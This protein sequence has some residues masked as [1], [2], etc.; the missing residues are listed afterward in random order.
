M[1]DMPFPIQEIYPAAISQQDSPLIVNSGGLALRLGDPVHDETVVY[2]PRANR[3]TEGVSLPAPRHHIAL[4]WDG[5][6][7]HA[8]GGFT[9]RGL[10]LWEMRSEHWVIDDP[11]N[12]RWREAEPLPGP[13][14]E[15]VTVFRDGFIHMIGGRVPVGDAN[16]D[17]EDH[18]DTGLHWA[19]E[20]ATGRWEE[21]AV[22]PGPRNS[23]TGAVLDG[24]IYVVSGRTV[25]SGNTPECHRYDPVRDRWEPIAG[26]PEARQQE[27]PRGQAGLAGAVLAGR[28]CVFGGE[29]FG[30]DEEGVYADA[31]AYDPVAGRWEALAPMAR[32]RHGLGAVA[33]GDAIYLLG[34]ARERG[35]SGVS[36]WLDRFRLP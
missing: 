22:L 28:L 27:A 12:G 24:H 15:A 35:G 18:T 25:A 21:R 20:L 33:I 6:L 19:Y 36:G 11:V 34:G 31:W 17:W 30:D 10:G 23:S 26:L 3:W 2:D 16:A 7:L 8:L 9:R 5:D 32:P 14:A 4:V 29:W 1:A 13:R